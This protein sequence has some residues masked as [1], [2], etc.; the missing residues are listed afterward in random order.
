MGVVAVGTGH[1]LFREPVV[2]GGGKPRLPVAFVADFLAWF[3][4]QGLIG[5]LMWLVAGEAVPDRC[6][7]MGM[8]FAE[9]VRM[10][11]E[12]EFVFRFEQVAGYLPF[13]CMAV[14][15]APFDVG[16]VS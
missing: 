6:G 5:R 7:S 2:H 8:W 15:A 9:Q 14:G 13:G 10:T 3:Y 11:E 12:A 1:A 4:K 16:E